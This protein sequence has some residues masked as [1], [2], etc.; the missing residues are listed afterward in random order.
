VPNFGENPAFPGTLDFGEGIVISLI[1]CMAVARAVIMNS[2]DSEFGRIGSGMVAFFLS[3]IVSGFVGLLVMS[4]YMDRR[5]AKRKNSDL[6]T[7]QK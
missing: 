5:S 4:L 1:I 3:F 6:D 2:P 7:K